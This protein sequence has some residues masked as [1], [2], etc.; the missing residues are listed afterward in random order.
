MSNK[1]QISTQAQA[2]GDDV[3]IVSAIQQINLNNQH[4]EDVPLKTRL[5]ASQIN[6]NLNLGHQVSDNFRQP[7]QQS[8]QQPFSQH[9]VI[10]QRQQQYE[11][12][13][14]KKQLDQPNEIEDDNKSSE[15]QEFKKEDKLILLAPSQPYSREPQVLKCE[16]CQNVMISKVES[17]PGWGSCLCC[18]LMFLTPFFFLFFLPFCMRQCKDAHHYCQSCSNKLG[19]YYFICE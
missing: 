7:I 4:Q 1:T 18:C 13:Q 19:T 11:M 6:Q 5:P 15:N 2:T 9:F 12:I 14:Q 8:I 10:Q 16:K 17:K 3:P